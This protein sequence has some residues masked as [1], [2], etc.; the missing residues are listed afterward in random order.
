MLKKL[1][2]VLVVIIAILGFLITRDWDSPELGQAILDKAGEA[3]GVKM[4]ASGFRFNVLKGLVL[5]DVK[6]S[7]QRDGRTMTLS[8][9]QFVVEHQLAPLL[10]GTIALDRVVAKRPQIEVVDPPA[11]TPSAAPAGGTAE[12]KAKTAPDKPAT[13][14]APG[15]DTE[16]TGF[17]LEVQ[18]IAIRDG[19]VVLR[20]QGETGATRIQG[21]DFDTENL[22]VAAGAG[23]LAGITADGKLTIDEVAFDAI[24]ITDTKGRFA[25]AGGKF[26]M[27][28]LTG[29]VA[30]GK[31]TANMQADFKPVPYTY[32]MSLRGEGLNLN[33]LIGATGGLGPAALNLE[34][35][36]AGASSRDVQANG[37]VQLAAG[38]LPDAPMLKRIDESLGKN[39]IVG[40]PYQATKADFT[41]ANNVATLAPFQFVTERA[42]MDLQGTANLEGPLDLDLSVATPREGIHIGGVGS[43]VLD[44]LADEQGWVPIPM[45]VTGTIEDPKVRPDTKALLAQAGA[46]V[47]REMQREATRKLEEKAS[48]LLEGLL[49]RKKK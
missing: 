46:G 49:G 11:A 10:S 44:V 24:K 35:H 41:V 5:D 9:E 45:A 23:D 13:E 3:T 1:I 38:S 40:A 16:A 32:H 7:T 36:G 34:A 31:V 30:Q 18:Q 22:T 14:P 8:V 48:G 27:P 26:D 6:A 15:E 20:R 39:I 17:T 29:N 19:S 43:D 12:T 37:S 21:L 33:Q 25:L 28:E 47:T 2:I 42:R 4:T